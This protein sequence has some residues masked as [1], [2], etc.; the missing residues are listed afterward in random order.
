MSKNGRTDDHSTV[1]AIV[2]ALYDAISFEPGGEPDWQRLQ[3]LF[4]PEGRLIPPAGPDGLAVLDLATFG[5]RSTA[6]MEE[7][8]LRPRGFRERE[9]GRRGERFGNVAH[10]M[11]G[12]ESLYAD[13]DEALGRG[14]NSIQLVQEDGRWWVLAIAWDAETPENPIPDPYLRAT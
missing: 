5:E 6:Y 13:T 1:D 12:Y 14:V 11:S 9:L 10:V 7:T 2:A 3:R 4:H 8:E